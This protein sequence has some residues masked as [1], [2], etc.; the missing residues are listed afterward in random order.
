MGIENS[1]PNKTT[2]G[3]FPV[4]AFFFIPVRLHGVLGD[5]TSCATARGQSPDTTGERIF[6]LCKQPKAI[7]IHSTFL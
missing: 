4:A 5:S 7:K 1:R 3:E 2:V 6:L